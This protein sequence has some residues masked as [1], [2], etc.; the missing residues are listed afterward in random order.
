MKQCTVFKL[1]LIPYDEALSFQ[2]EL[3][4]RIREHKGKDSY[5]V[6]L[7]HP[8]VITV[9]RNGNA[10]NILV[11]EDEL[12]KKGIALRKIDRGGDVTYH[13]P[14]QLVGYPIIS[15]AYHKKTIRQYVELL[16][17]AMIQTLEH[18]GVKAE[19]KPKYIGAWVNNEKIGFVGVRVSK[20]VTYHGFALNVNPDLNYFNYINPCGI[21]GC[22]ITSIGKLTGKNPVMSDVTKEFV[23]CY[24]KIFDVEPT[25]VKTHLSYIPQKVAML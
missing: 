6:L 23:S 24:N 4:E 14:G 3:V 12:K 13:G 8:P 21:N 5:L 25:V 9:G 20:G 22:K 1:G 16:E 18:F 17:E 19:R 10:K 15:L 7:E 2:F 11:N